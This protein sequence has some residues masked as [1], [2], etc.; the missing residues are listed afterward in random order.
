MVI[1]TSAAV[2]L[3]V[4]LVEAAGVEPASESSEAW[5]LHAYLSISSR[6]CSARRAGSERG[7][8]SRFSSAAPRRFADA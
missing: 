2:G 8:A 7:P 1:L 3:P 5:L 6:P 4:A